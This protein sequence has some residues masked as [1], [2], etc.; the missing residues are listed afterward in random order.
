[1]AKYIIVIYC[2]IYH[3]MFPFRK[4]ADKLIKAIKEH[5][6]QERETKEGGQVP[7]SWF[8]AKSTL[9]LACFC[10]SLMLAFMRS[11]VIYSRK[12]VPMLSKMKM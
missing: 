3:K 1:M 11:V 4:Q 8:I 2:E 6:Q 12:T 9:N 10:Q 7:L 5:Y